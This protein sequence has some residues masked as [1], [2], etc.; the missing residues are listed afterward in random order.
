[1][2]ARTRRSEYNCRGT[3]NVGLSVTEGKR[4]RAKPIKYAYVGGG[5][6]LFRLENV[7]RLSACMVRV[8][9]HARA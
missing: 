6:K 4:A 7:K 8:S 3:C 9:A 5:A 1:M 2:G